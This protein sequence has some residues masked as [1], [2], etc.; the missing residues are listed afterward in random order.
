MLKFR[1]Y[2]FLGYTLFSSA[3]ILLLLIWL[4]AFGRRGAFLWV[5][6]WA[7]NGILSAKYILGV[8]YEVKGEIPDYPA[9]YAAKHQSAWETGFLQTVIRN[10]AYVLKKELTYIPL[11]N[12]IMYAAGYVAVDRKNN[13]GALR[14]MVKGV[15]KQLAKGSNIIIFPEGTRVA[16][17][18]RGVMK[19]GVAAL[20]KMTQTPIIPVS[21][22]SGRLWPRNSFIKKPGIITVTFHPPIEKGLS[23]E[24][25]MRV[26]EKKINFSN[27]AST[28]P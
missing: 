24:E 27:P 3:A 6:I 22:N 1:A 18:E 13:A 7:K 12:L 4:A 14:K 20:Y 26:L 11:Y 21:L 9:I 10:P 17:G 2:I 5:Y 8:T 19:P 28:R 23:R 15:K 25:F 16:Y